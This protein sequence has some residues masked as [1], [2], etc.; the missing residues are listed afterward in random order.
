MQKPNRTIPVRQ[1]AE[2]LL[3]LGAQRNPGGWAAHSRYVALGAETIARR[4]PA[5]D[6]EAA[7]IVGLLHDIGRQEGVTNM[8][9]V[10]D[11]YRYLLDLGYPDAARFCL[12]HSFPVKDVH[13]HAGV[14][15][16]TDAEVA[17]VAEFLA[18]TE[19]TDMDSLIQLCDALAL[20]SGFC[21]IEKRLVDVALR[22]GINPTT[23][24][25]WR[26]TFNLQTHFEQI[27]GASIYTL[28]PGVVDNTFD[29]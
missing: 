17:F 2:R 26:A 23:L 6:A 13:A 1:E 22:H 28:L 27:I 14:W 29:R 4:H 11:G 24:P 3:E 18:Q 12:T 25:R 19:Y 8:R 21:L 10:L 7:Y 20:A 16:C 9:H 5:L 15:D